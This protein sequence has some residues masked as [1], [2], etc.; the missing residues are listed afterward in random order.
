[1]TV[2]VALELDNPV[3]EAVM[4]PVPVVTGVNVVEALPP[5]ADTGD[6]GLNEPETPVAVNVIA[7]VAF[8][9]GLPE[10]SCMVTV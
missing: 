2:N 1:V 3:A 7:F 6:G 8:G 5:L 4:V 9:T 10:A